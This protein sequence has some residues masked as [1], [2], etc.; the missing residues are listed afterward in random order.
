MKIR[1][2]FFF[3]TIFQELTMGKSEQRCAILIASKDASAGYFVYFFQAFIFNGQVQLTKN[4][5]Y[6]MFHNS[7]IFPGYSAGWISGASLIPAYL[8][9][10]NPK[11]WLIC[12]LY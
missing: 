11:D 2:D 12:H 9:E 4:D 6:S 1:H 3:L 7:H 8:Y 5:R 10:Y